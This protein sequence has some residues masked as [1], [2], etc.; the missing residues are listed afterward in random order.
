MTRKSSFL[1]DILIFFYLNSFVND[2]TFEILKQN[3]NFLS[4]S[5]SV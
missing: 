4:A 1:K 3:F 5:R 2:L